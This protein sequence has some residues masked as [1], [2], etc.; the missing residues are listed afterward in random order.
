MMLVTKQR[1]TA[2]AKTNKVVLGCDNLA[3]KLVMRLWPACNK[4]VNKVVTTLSKPWI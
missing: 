3:H 4:L 1:E 2:H